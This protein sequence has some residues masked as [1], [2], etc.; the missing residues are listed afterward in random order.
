VGLWLAVVDPPSALRFRPELRDQLCLALLAAL[1]GIAALRPR[2]L[3]APAIA[4]TV[5]ILYLPTL[6]YGFVYDDFAFARPW[7]LSEIVSTLAGSWDPAGLSTDYFRPVASATLALDYRIWGASPPGYH[8]TNLL[9]HALLGWLGFRLLCRLG[10][11]PLASLAGALAWSAHPLG[12]TAVSWA[13]Q[14]TDG[15]VA[16]FYLAA[17]LLLLSPRVHLVGLLACYC[18]AL[19]SKELAVTWP[20]LAALALL[21]AG[22]LEHRA[23]R[24]RAIRL[25]SLLT[26]A[27][28]AFWVSIFPRRALGRLGEAQVEMDLPADTGL[29]V[30]PAFFATVF[31]PM[32]YESWWQGPIGGVS[33]L[34]LASGLLLPLLAALAARRSRAGDSGRL[35][36]LGVAWPVV[37]A[38]PMLGM[39][40]LDLYAKG[41]LLCVGFGIL[42]GVVVRHLEHRSAV[43]AV[44]LVLLPAPW[45]GSLTRATSSAWG[46]G[47][48]LWERNTRWTRHR[49]DWKAGLTPEMRQLFREQIEE[50]SHDERW[51]RGGR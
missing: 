30:V 3:A 2:A 9:L 23:E 10:L 22:P 28:L 24:W 21:L 49:P 29:R 31:A 35:V 40:G 16:L 39:A 41:L 11:S 20:M 42:W 4:G 27:Y 50:V 6:G 36:V 51:V 46:P 1:W 18:L 14:R 44:A 45:L 43:L 13:N 25:A 33:R 15:L 32:D 17:L 8:L 38:L 47:G 12:A 7:P 19:G 48:F 34:W 5:G 37:T 26:V